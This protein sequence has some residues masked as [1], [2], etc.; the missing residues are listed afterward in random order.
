M[1]PGFTGARPWLMSAPA[2]WQPLDRLRASRAA[3]LLLRLQ[4]DISAESVEAWLGPMLQLRQPGITGTD[5]VSVRPDLDSLSDIAVGDL[6]KPLAVLFGGVCFVLLLVSGNVATLLLARGAARD[7]ELAVRRALGASRL[8]QVRHVL[9]ESLLLAMAGGVLGMLLAVWGVAVLRVLGAEALPR[10]ALVGIDW[11]VLGF[12]TVLTCVCGIAVGLVPAL[13]Y[14]G[15]SGTKLLASLSGAGRLEQG[16]TRWGGVRGTLVVAEIALSMLLL[17]GAGLM[18]KSFLRLLPW[19]AGFEVVDRVR[20]PLRLAQHPV[21]DDSVQGSVRRLALAHEAASRLRAV[22]GVR[23]VALSRF[24]PFVRESAVSEVRPD[25]APRDP[26]ARALTAHQRAVSPNYFTVMS[27]TLH[28]GREF[29]EGDGAGAPRVVIVN[30]TAARRWW[31][32]QEAV[33]RQLFFTEGGR[34]EVVA[35]VVGVVGDTRFD[36]LSTRTVP[37]IFV[38]FAQAPPR[39]FNFVVFA[40]AGT[41]AVRAP[42]RRAVWSVDPSL[43]IEE[44]ETL[45]DIAGEA[46]STPRFYS[47]VMGVFAAIALVL[48][49]AGI[50]SVLAYTVTRRS[51]EIGIRMALGAARSG[52]MALV[53]RQGMRLV[54]PGIAIGVLGASMLTRALQSVLFEVSPT[55]PSVFAWT[56]GLLLA[57]A[58]A[59]C[60]IPALRAGRL[61]PLKAIRT[62]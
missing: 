47:V 18:L 11:R 61:D 21:Y 56:V 7:R 19:E 17:V 33:G 12:A 3:G 9:L 55:D 28:R 58:V 13:V 31:P 38:P 37:E 62:E 27:M 53:L 59:S 6:R 4:R 25:G 32:G 45:A 50:H 20:V 16:R 5:S 60:V 15:G 26:T 35:D 36:G 22:P 8:R 23:D 51:R 44:V 2:I 46:V 40:D 43:P 34:H 41:I 42:L 10:L 48:S 30:E 52:V 49:A 57:V 14:T 54:V 39:N 1:P 29:D 24:V